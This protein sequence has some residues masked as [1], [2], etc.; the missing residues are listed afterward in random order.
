M[1]RWEKALTPAIKAAAAGLGVAVFGPMVGGLGVWV[2]GA[3]GATATGLVVK[4]AD[5]FGE[6]A[7]EK[8]LDS[9]ADYLLEHLKGPARTLEDAYRLALRSGL[10]RVHSDLGAVCPDWFGN[11][12]ACLSDR[13][14]LSL[15]PIGTGQPFPTGVDR[16]LRTTLELLDAIG[17]NKRNRA[18]ISCR[19]V[20]EELIAGL[21]QHLPDYFASEF[22]SLIYTE[23]YS[24]AWRQLESI[25]TRQ[26]VAIVQSSHN[27]VLNQIKIGFD[28]QQLANQALE[29]LLRETM[30]LGPRH[31]E[32]DA[33]S[34][35]LTYSLEEQ[36]AVLQGYLEWLIS[37][38]RNLE[39]G[40]E[41]HNERVEIPLEEVYVA[42]RGYPGAI[43]EIQQSEKLDE[44]SAHDG[45]QEPTVWL[46]RNR[47]LEFA[48]Q[49]L[50][51]LD[52]AQAYR[53]SSSLIILGDPGSGKTTLLR[54]LTLTSARAMLHGEKE[55][56]VPALSVDPDASSSESL[57][58]LGPVKLPI[59]LRVG[60][61]HKL[62]SKKK[63]TLSL[64]DALAYGEEFGRPLYP[65]SHAKGRTRIE[66]QLISSLI[67]DFIRR[68]QAVV[69]LDGLDEI[70][71]PDDR[72]LIVRQ[73]HKF[74]DDFIPAQ[75]SP[76]A[77]SGNKLVVT[78]RRV[79]YKSN[80]LREQVTPFTVEELSEASIRRFS[81]AWHHAC[82]KALT[83]LPNENP[84]QATS[85]ASDAFLK[86]I[87]DSQR[88]PLREL[89]SNPLMLN[90]LCAT[91]LENNH[92][93]PQT[94][95]GLYE[96]LIERGFKRAWADQD[97]RNGE[98][99]SR[100]SDILI[101]VA[102]KIHET[103][104]TG[105]VSR[106]ELEENIGKLAKLHGSDAEVSEA[107]TDL[108]YSIITRSGLIAERGLGKFGFRHLTIQE[109]LLGKGLVRD[110]ERAPSLLLARATDPRSHEALLLGLGHL[111]ECSSLETFES[112]CTRLLNRSSSP[113]EDSWPTGAIIIAEALREVRY[114]SPA[115]V[116]LALRQLLESY[117]D[118]SE[119]SRSANLAE[120]VE[121]TFS[122]VI[123]SASIPQ[124]W[125][126]E[127]EG[128]LIEALRSGSIRMVNAA[129][130]IILKCNLFLTSLAEPLLNVLRFDNEETD[131][132]INR[133]L[134]TMASFKDN[135]PK[136]HQPFSD[137]FVAQLDPKMVEVLRNRNVVISVRQRGQ[138][139]SA[140]RRLDMG[141]PAHLLPMRI[142][143]ESSEE[144]T[145]GIR[146]NL[147][148]MQ[149]I[150]GLYG[151]LGNFGAIDLRRNLGASRVQ[152]GSSVVQENMRELAVYMD[153][154]L[155]PKWERISK[156]SLAFQA[157]YIYRDS[158]L[159]PLLLRTLGES[160]SFDELIGTL[161]RIW[162]DPAC[163]EAEEL[164][165]VYRFSTSQNT[166]EAASGLIDLLSDALVALALLRQ[167]ISEY[168]HSEYA[169]STKASAVLAAQ[170]E[171][172]RI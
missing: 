46:E 45:F 122:L 132:V 169:Q 120:F 51:T 13:E 29:S 151:G 7:A 143:L 70:A 134:S 99:R 117:A 6:R 67:L 16:H 43:T 148:S 92:E 66:T 84:K 10:R 74:I 130:Q 64:V 85:S 8:F 14:F 144:L 115:I 24:A 153:T 121:A 142:A 20:P 127:A 40:V 129:A 101:G 50:K 42:L 22:Q 56:R 135:L 137:R 88:Q 39:E 164:I 58:S 31:E 48:S 114:F 172:Q 105:L 90:L 33:R 157:S 47:K 109:Y 4:Y 160:S 141:L 103:S 165:S 154:V 76:V 2:V 140:E 112:V 54:W 37:S 131:F 166:D 159:T 69:F 72:K 171:I 71:N 111:S 138:R 110:P 35:P 23:E 68:D 44:E 146:N 25:L 61:F 60:E 32:A 98:W 19:A 79:G 38:L 3:L 170:R 26:L 93:L 15:T 167:D 100:L 17:A 145:A 55:S 96:V 156:R 149:L 59:Y 52:L 89:A 152:I 94:R 116:G 150:V 63:D 107:R 158:P 78:S 91:N 102:I 62:W 139:T 163:D 104:S 136:A 97:G 34:S 86:Q 27:Q 73:I 65:T 36:A 83:L 133:T 128:Q 95:A 113:G 30:R 123:R 28:K 80:A 118:Y 119:S 126:A 11:W 87:F 81:A 162:Q 49:S 155:Q 161:I 125:S 1:I 21:E 168:L 53:D 57:V 82:R 9:G 18:T 41:I 12:D 75:S 5:A 106:V 108:C 147:Q 124:D 77:E